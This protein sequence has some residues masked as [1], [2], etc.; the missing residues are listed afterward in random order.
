MCTLSLLFLFT[1]ESREL[2]V[3]DHRTVN[4]VAFDIGLV[5]VYLFSVH[6]VFP[7]RGYP[8]SFFGGVGG[9]AGSL[10]LH[11]LLSS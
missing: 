3:G 6:Y 11:K 7:R 2:N 10:L 8:L 4:T 1:N 5:I 9:C